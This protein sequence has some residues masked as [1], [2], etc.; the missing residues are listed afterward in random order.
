MTIRLSHHF[1]RSR[2]N[3]E[4]SAVINWLEFIWRE[5]AAAAG[6]LL[7]V[8]TKFCSNFLFRHNHKWVIHSA[9]TRDFCIGDPISRLNGFLNVKVVVATLN[10]SVIV[11]LTAIFHW[12][13]YWSQSSGMLCGVNGR[14]HDVWCL[15]SSAH[16]PAQ[17]ITIAAQRG[18]LQPISEQK[19]VA[20]EAIIIFAGPIS[21]LSIANW[22]LLG[23]QD[24]NITLA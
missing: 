12:H 4:A 15:N 17:G 19:A 21:G 23:A 9:P 24:H 14:W 8:S 11:Q 18:M 22:A 7:K 5:T 2:N 13:L 3:C 6:C 10:L 20:V 16:W 1:S